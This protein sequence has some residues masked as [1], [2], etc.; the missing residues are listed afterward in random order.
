M[1]WG[2]IEAAKIDTIVSVFAASLFAYFAPILQLN[3]GKCY[4]CGYW[5]YFSKRRI[6]VSHPF[7]VKFYP[8]LWGKNTRL[9]CQII[10]AA[11]AGCFAFQLAFH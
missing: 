6:S 10:L 9:E 3:G 5:L 7:A 2:T 4:D 11:R 1:L 8:T